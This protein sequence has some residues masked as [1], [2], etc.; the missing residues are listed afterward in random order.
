VTSYNQL[1][2]FEVTGSYFAVADP[3]ISGV[4]NSP[5]VQPVSATVTFT[6]R[7]PVGE[8]LYVPDYLVT[9]AY[10]AEQTVS[11]LGQPTSGTYTLSFGGDTT[12]PIDYDADAAEV[13]TA[14]QGMASIG[15]GNCTVVAGIEPNS[16][17]VEFTNTLGLQA[18]PVMSGN[19]DDL[20]TAE[21]QGYCEVTVTTTAEGS[22]QIVAPT[23]I[24]LPPIT[25][26]IWS[27]I[28]STIDYADTP[29][30]QLT[31]NTPVLNLTSNLIYD[32]TFTNITFNGASQTIAPFA[33]IAPTDDSSIC[34]TDGTI[35]MLDY[36]LP[37]TVPW[38][39]SSTNV[40]MKMGNVTPMRRA[41]WRERA[42]AR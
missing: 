8:L 19:A 11:I 18:I 6:P 4:V 12:D 38:T 15:S 10:N 27:G 32:V 28:L 22:P 9:V 30:I 41:N 16:F 29:G 23:A 39:P 7:L 34:L 5:V 26:R 17:D 42:V 33:F 40:N 31:S 2:F 20:A 37:S 14:V 25:A 13:Q 21:G 1:T 36:Q 35:D 3:S 24:A